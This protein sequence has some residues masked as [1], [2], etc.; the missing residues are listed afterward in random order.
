MNHHF[1]STFAHFGDLICLQQSLDGYWLQDL[2][3]RTDATASQIVLVIQCRR[4]KQRGDAKKPDR[5]TRYLTARL[6]P[7]QHLHLINIR[8]ILSRSDQEIMI[9]GFL[10]RHSFPRIKFQ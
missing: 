5:S 4:S 6:N 9:K 10:G 2:K 8:G 1:E 3:A 7:L